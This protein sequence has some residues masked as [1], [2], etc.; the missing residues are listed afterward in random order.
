[1]RTRLTRCVIAVVHESSDVSYHRF[2]PV[3]TVPFPCLAST[4]SNS[5][6]VPS[7]YTSSLIDSGVLSPSI[8]AA[9]KAAY[10]AKLDASLDAA[11]PQN[12]VVPELERTRGWGETRWAELGEWEE[13]V[14]TGVEESVLKEVGRTS[15]QVEDGFVSL[16]PSRPRRW[17]TD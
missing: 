16:V 5:R 10:T 13:N 4:D 7:L 1:M 9:S 8:V 17:F 12:F 6:S 15:V 11:L 14:E 2:P 3:R